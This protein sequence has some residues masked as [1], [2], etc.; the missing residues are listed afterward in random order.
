MVI[1]ATRSREIGNESI[2][3]CKFA[4]FDANKDREFSIKIARV[5]RR[6]R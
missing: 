1:L 2:I 5:T 6:E 4:I 3:G